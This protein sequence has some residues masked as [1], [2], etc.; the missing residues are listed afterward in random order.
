MKQSN[1]EIEYGGML[2]CRAYE[3]DKA[4]SPVTT[5]YGFQLFCFHFSPRKD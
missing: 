5:E 1:N 2:A 3:I 4:H